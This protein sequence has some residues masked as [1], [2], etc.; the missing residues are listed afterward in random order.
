MSP[1]RL[2]VSLLF[3][4]A[5]L[6]CA[7][8][9]TPRENWPGLASTGFDKDIEVVLDRGNGQVYF[10]RRGD[11]VRFDLKANKVDDGPRPIA[12]HWPGLDD[13]SID[14]AFTYTGTGKAY[15]FRGSQYLRF[16]LGAFK[17]VDGYPKPIA[18][19]WAGLEKGGF[20]RGVDTA[21]DMGNGKVYFFRGRHCTRFDMKADKV[22]DGFPKLIAD[23][24]PGL[25]KGGFDRDVRAAIKWGKDKVYFFRGRE[26]VRYDLVARRVDPGHPAPICPDGV[27]TKKETKPW[28]VILCKYSDFPKEPYPVSFYRAA[29]TAGKAREFDYFREVSYG[30]IDMTGSRIF[31]WFTMPK[32]STKDALALKYPAGRSTL[33]DWG[34]EV[35]KDQRID[36]TPFYG[37]V[38]V[39]NYGTDA[40]YAGGNRVVLASDWNPTFNFHELGHGFGLGHTWFARP[41][42]EYGDPWDIMSA[43]NVHIFKNKFGLNGPGMNAFNLKKLGCIPADRIWNSNGA[44]S[45]QTI[46]LAALNQY[47][48]NGYLMAWIAPAPGSASKTGYYVEFRRK[49]G[50]DAG[51][52]QDAVLVHEVRSDGISYLLSRSNRAD[53][54]DIQVL[55]DQEFEIAE[56]KLTIKAVSFDADAS[57]AKV[58]ITIAE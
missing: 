37:V 31:G 24:W 52:P 22:D 18:G 41:D 4:L 14:A 54:A 26:Y 5:F 46:T 9:Q 51:I 43:M 34:I 49:K 20:D 11:Y 28:A 10:L 8:A 29:F 1:T 44:A 17:V 57:T 6:P 35:A 53:R 25:E 56:R 42:E 12:G 55:P 40:G 30:N 16:D 39:L 13:Q 50:W 23:E 45:S 58:A 2:T 19:A 3:G 47:D 15:F 33:H 21:L 32:R 38:V 7:R 36:L 48:A 27:S